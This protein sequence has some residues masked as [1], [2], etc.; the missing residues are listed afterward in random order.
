VGCRLR[1]DVTFAPLGRPVLLHSN[2]LLSAC[3]SGQALSYFQSSVQQGEDHALG[4][5]G[6]MF[7][8]GLGVEGGAPDPAMALKYFKVRVNQA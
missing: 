6:H 5:L 7:S 3:A 4:H 8:R 1:L 2:V